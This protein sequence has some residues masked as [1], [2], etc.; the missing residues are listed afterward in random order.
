MVLEKIPS[1]GG[2]GRGVWIFSGT[3]QWSCSISC[4]CTTSSELRSGRFLT[5]KNWE[6]EEAKI[7]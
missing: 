3:T 7:A 2:G 4:T 5:H 1:I 6:G